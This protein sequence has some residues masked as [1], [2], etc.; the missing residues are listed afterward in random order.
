[1]RCCWLSS[2]FLALSLACAADPADSGAV[3][4]ADEVGP[5][6]A[7]PATDL[8]A[9]GPFGAGYATL[10]MSYD[11]TVRGGQR[12]LHLAVWYPSPE[13]TVGAELRYR[14][15]LVSADAV[16][17]APLRDGRYPVVVFSHGHQAFAEAS[18]RLMAHL[19][20]H[21]WLVVAPDHTDNTFF[22]GPDRETEIYVQRPLDVSAVLDFVAEAAD[23][24]L[25]TAD[26]DAVVAVGH[27][28]GGYTLFGLAGGAYDIEGLGPAC[29][30]GT[31]PAS[32]CST[33]TDALGG[34]LQAG[35]SDD[36]VDAWIPMAPGD[37]NLFS[38]DG[39]AALSAPV[40][41]L[42]G[43]LDPRVGDNPE[44]YWAAMGRGES[45]HVVVSG[46]GH[47][48]FTD[49]SEVLESFDGLIG[50]EEGWD[51][52]NAYVLA[53]ARVHGLGDDDLRPVLDGEVVISAA[54][55]VQR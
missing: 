28:F 45:R 9:P 13:P 18:G 44:Q 40:M 51:I 15:L 33:Y 7:D 21:G 19:A 52:T 39:L 10:S 29:A 35:F 14:D 25:A 47:Q 53:F 16:L 11:D 37:A 24:P 31:G 32:F 1:M 27:S 46:G 36:R 43:D 54:A 12:D 17:D 2:P 30:A 3:P 26:L 4:A 34:R 6:Y 20:S 5:T 38:A 48:T 23:G 41:V 42:S 50:A 8:P 22:D 49:Y 55:E